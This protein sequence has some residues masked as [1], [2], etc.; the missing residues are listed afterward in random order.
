[1]RKIKPSRIDRHKVLTGKAL[2]DRTGPLSASIEETR[3]RK[4]HGMPL[5]HPFRVQNLLIFGVCLLLWAMCSHSA[6]GQVAAGPPIAPRV[7]GPSDERIDELL[8]SLLGKRLVDLPSGQ[9]GANNELRDTITAFL[10]A[11]EKIAEFVAE[12]EKSDEV[13]SGSRSKFPTAQEAGALLENLRDGW[14]TPLRY[15]TYFGK[16]SLTSDGPDSVSNTFDD[17][18][19][20]K[21]GVW[22]DMVDG[23]FGAWIVDPIGAVIF[24]DIYPLVKQI[25]PLT[26]REPANAPRLPFVVLC[27]LGV[28]A[29]T[30]VR[31]FFINIRG[32]WHA[33]RLTM[34][35]YDDPDHPGEVSHFQALSSALSATVGL[36]NIAGVAI[37]VCAGG[38]GAVFWLVVA[39]FF[40]MSSKFAECTLGQLYRKVSPDGVVSGGAMHY[41]RDGLAMYGLRPIGAFLA[42]L[43][44]VLCIG[45]SFGGG[46]SF[47]VGQS[48]NAIREEPAFAIID[49]YPIIYG[50]LMAV[51]TGVVIIG[52]I[53][54]IGRV[55]DKIVPVMCLTYV[56]ISLY[57]IFRNYDLIIPS[58]KLI[59]SEAFTLKAGWGGFIGT[60]IMGIR[61]ASFSNEAGVGSAAIAHSAAKTN[62]PVSEGI[63]A[64][65]EPFVDTIVVCTM[66][67]L[68]IVF[69][70]AWNGEEFRTRV[71]KTELAALTKAGDPDAASKAK[72]IAE[73]EGKEIATLGAAEK[74]AAVMSR[75][76]QRGGAPWCRF[77]LYATVF[78]F[79][80]ST[81]ISWSYYGERCWAHLFGEGKSIYYKIIFLLCTVLGSIITEGKI[82]EFSDLMIFGMAFPNMIGLII[83]SNHIKRELDKYWR[84]YKTGQ[85]ALHPN[86]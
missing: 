39:G 40:G 7:E 6:I 43:F 22:F 37:A 48:L 45:A 49:K 19:T 52:G 51:M 77:A 84:K 86:K 30:T 56:A 34:G 53:K 25:L 85:L 4:D 41:L 60:M 32:F 12:K 78:L 13:K 42:T 27:L 35:A 1:M 61:R 74:G 44:A 15:A 59:F 82:L 23:F 66:S 55:A 72:A 83:M 47:Q 21:N 38:P 33:I 14:N 24:Y 68:V 29:F 28:A 81:V 57:I 69:T 9:N 63:V 65:L 8:H 10:V 3:L 17:I 54:S 76:M 26:D 70:G 11:Q 80:Y 58:F 2:E 50:I 31:M 46:C 20:A 75:A 5:A 67:A 16:Y 79:A 64:L 71:E 36:G 73:R 62:E 18:S